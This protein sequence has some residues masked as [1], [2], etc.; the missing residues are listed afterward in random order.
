MPT[1]YCAVLRTE[2]NIKERLFIMIAWMPKA[3]VQAALGGVVLGRANDIDD[4]DLIDIGMIF[5]TV[6]VFCILI[7]APIG[8]VLTAILGPKLLNKSDPPS[9]QF[10]RIQP[11]SHTRESG[12]QRFEKIEADESR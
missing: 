12:C 9:Q 1:A 11:S 2:L 6:A 8:A 7:T 5:L 3:T 4:D 10:H